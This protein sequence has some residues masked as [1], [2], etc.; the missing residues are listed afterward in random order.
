MKISQTAIVSSLVISGQGV[1][2]AQPSPRSSQSFWRRTGRRVLS[3]WVATL[4]R[5]QLEKPTGKTLKDFPWEF[6][7]TRMWPAKMLLKLDKGWSQGKGGLKVNKLGFSSGNLER[8]TEFSCALGGHLTLKRWTLRSTW[9]RPWFYG[10]KMGMSNRFFYQFFLW[11]S[12][13]FLHD[14]PSGKHT[15]NY[16]KSP[17]LMGNSTINGHFQ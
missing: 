1:P 9:H 14:I 17:F 7:S 6:S 3:W 15:K 11:W 5:R 2:C 13:F 8:N 16:G 12:P 10:Q 4:P